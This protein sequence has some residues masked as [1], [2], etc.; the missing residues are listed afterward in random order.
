MPRVDPVAVQ[1]GDQAV[2]ER[3]AVAA[4]RQRER[5]EDAERQRAGQ[6]V[7]PVADRVWAISRR[8]GAGR[9]SGSASQ[10]WN[11]SSACDGGQPVAQLGEAEQP[12]GRCQADDLERAR[13]RGHRRAVRVGQLHRVGVAVL[14]VGQPQPAWASWSCGAS[15]GSGNRRP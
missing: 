15:A 11:G 3:Q 8:A 6:V 7:A 12:S 1:V 13:L 9:S 2:G 5:L 10:S 14:G 4:V